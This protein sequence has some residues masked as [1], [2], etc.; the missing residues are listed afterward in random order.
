MN[1]VSVIDTSAFI[2]DTEQ[3]KNNAAPY[4]E[5]SKQ[6]KRFFTVIEKEKPKILIRDQMITEMING[7][8]YADTTHHYDW[9]QSIAL[10]LS[11]VYGL[12]ISFPV[13][14]TNGFSS[15]PNII[16]NH[17]NSTVKQE[18]QYLI[19]HIH[20]DKETTI[21]LT[22]APIWDATGHLVT[23]VTAVEREHETIISTSDELEK[24]FDNFKLKFD[25][26]PKHDRIK[27]YAEETAEDVSILSCFDGQDNTLPQAILEKAVPF[28]NSKKLYSYDT[29]NNT[30]V[31][32]HPHT[33][34]LYH[35]WDVVSEKVP[36]EIKR[37]FGKR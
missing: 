16:R 9:G 5:L 18:T 17:Y 13:P 30:Y 28:K 32:F 35:G 37:K 10:F 3:L 1:F 19:A 23:L 7:F 25:H 8:P 11:K 31:C 20:S 12:A 15:R 14:Q 4:Y 29:T 21:F 26:N 22:F 6:L 24:F 33:N 34:N 36:I 27:K 2:W